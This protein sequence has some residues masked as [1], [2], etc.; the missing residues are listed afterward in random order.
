M[1]AKKSKM[2]AKF[3]TKK[4]LTQRQH[5]I[6]YMSKNN[7]S[8]TFYFTLTYKILK[9]LMY[10]QQSYGSLKFHPVI[11]LC[12]FTELK[13]QYFLNNKHF[14]IFQRRKGLRNYINNTYTKY[15][16]FWYIKIRVIAL[17][18]ISI[19]FQESTKIDL[20]GKRAR[21]VLKIINM[22]G[23]SP[24]KSWKII[25]YWQVTFPKWPPKIQDGCQTRIANKYYLQNDTYF[26]TCQR[27][28]GLEHD[29][30]YIH[31]KFENISSINNGVMVIWNLILSWPF[32]SLQNWRLNIF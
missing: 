3:I 32:V 8:R 5:I 22:A 14:N 12:H 18:R 1:A 17:C 29:I 9:Q 6:L 25:W 7:K 28:K 26:H 20:I 24:F 31:T 16:W 11:A 15:E 27:T 19:I 4:I 10:K 13:T 30:L 2:A 21:L 23:R